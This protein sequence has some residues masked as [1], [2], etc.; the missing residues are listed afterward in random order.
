[1]PQS[2]PDPVSPLCL[3]S[4]RDVTSG[5]A[6]RWHSRCA[7]VRLSSAPQ[8]ALETPR[9][10]LLLNGRWTAF[11]Q[12][13]SNY[14]PL[15][16]FYN[17]ASHSPIHTHVH[18]CIDTFSHSPTYSPIHTHKHSPFH[19]HI[20]TRTAVSTMRHATASSSAAVGV[21]SEEVVRIEPATS[22]SP[23]DPLCPL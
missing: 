3:G 13:F 7:L 18:P 12:P 8:R 21:K 17:I 19:A 6:G 23:S 1:M 16:A 5:C 22:L 4:E 10:P 15:K 20:H 9:C 11:I 14:W 2:G